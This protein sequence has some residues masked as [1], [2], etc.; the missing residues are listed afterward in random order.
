MGLYVRAADAIREAFG[1]A[2]IVI[3][4]CGT[5]GTRPRGHTSLTGAADAQISVKRDDL[6]NIIAKVEY[7]KDGPEGDEL[8]SSLEL[9]DVGTD[10]DGDKITSCVVRPATSIGVKVK[11]TGQAAIA[12]RILQ[13]TIADE[14]AI[15]PLSSN[16]PPNTQTCSEKSWRAACY[17]KMFETDT[18]QTTKQKAFVRVRTTLLLQNFVGKY[19]DHIWLG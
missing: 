13:D 1:C 16:I 18:P 14:G 5:E 6:K 8:V 7:M 2:V 17:A 19:D 15:P 3:H 11:A 9:V 4:H 10:D 12:R